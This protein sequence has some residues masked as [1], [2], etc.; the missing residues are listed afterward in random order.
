[1]SRMNCRHRRE[2]RHE[3]AL[4]R[5]AER[6]ERTDQEQLERL[7]SVFGPGLGAQKERARLLARIEKENNNG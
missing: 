6:N 4:L 3:A 1:M 2:T 7:D 5:Q